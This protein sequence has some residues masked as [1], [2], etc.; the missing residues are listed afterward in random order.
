M[1]RYRPA[2]ELRHNKLLIDGEPQLFEGFTLLHILGQGANGVVVAARDLSLDRDVAIKV[3]T[4]QNR[5]ANQGIA[6]AAKLARLQHPL[7]CTVWA[8]HPEVHKPWAVLEQVN[9]QTVAEW[10]QQPRTF[11][12]R[13]I[14]WTLVAKALRHIHKAGSVHGD[15]HAQNLMLT[16]DPTG[17]ASFFIPP[18]FSEMGFGFG[19]KVLD[20]GA[21]AL[22]D[23]P[24]KLVVRE[25]DV[26]LE[27]F[28]RLIQ[29]PELLGLIEELSPGP[30]DRLRELDAV[31]QLQASL[32]LLS[33]ADEAWNAAN[34]DSDDW[35]EPEAQEARRRISSARS[36]A[37]NTICKFRIFSIPRVFEY[38]LGYPIYKTRFLVEDLGRRLGF[39]SLHDE[40]DSVPA[41]SLEILEARYKGLRDVKWSSSPM[42]PR[43]FRAGSRASSRTRKS[44]SSAP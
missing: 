27:T 13:F 40:N 44:P 25:S 3:W 35:D 42:A 5:R 15:P 29:T 7:I 10:L 33:E 41:N 12:Q 18:E 28:E 30:T 22:W 20:A 11:G 8:F 31:A 32:L 37:L 24:K 38:L 2:A 34:Y 19:L 43:E 36:L 26:I 4:R 9:G 1:P 39:D 17:L 6:E 23:D 21:S 16:S 14:V